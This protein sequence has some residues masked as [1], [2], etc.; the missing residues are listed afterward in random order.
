MSIRV[1]Q[2]LAINKN[3]DPDNDPINIRGI[4]VMQLIMN[5]IGT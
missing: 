1:K 2:K 5:F 3:P 4:L